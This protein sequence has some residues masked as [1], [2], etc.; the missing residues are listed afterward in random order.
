MGR[1][2]AEEAR[3]P[4][5]AIHG[6]PTETLVVLMQLHLALTPFGFQVVTI[7]IQLDVSAGK[8]SSCLFTDVYL[9]HG[10]KPQGHE[11][12][13]A[14]FAW[15]KAQHLV[16]PGF[17][18]ASHGGLLSLLHQSKAKEDRLFGVY[19]DTMQAYTM[20]PRIH[21][22]LGGKIA[23]F[24]AVRW[25]GDM[26]FP[27]LDV[28]PIN[29]KALQQRDLTAHRSPTAALCNNDAVAQDG[30]ET[31]EAA[32]GMKE[33]GGA[34][35]LHGRLLARTH[36]L[37]ARAE[38]PQRRLPGPPLPWRP[39]RRHQALQQVRLARCPPIPRRLHPPIAYS[40]PPSPISPPLAIS[41]LGMVVVAQE[42]AR[43]VGQLRSERLANLIGCCCE[44]DERLLVAEF[45]PH[46][47]LAKHLF[48]CM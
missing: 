27:L 15:D 19:H 44:G 26:L 36:R 17:A 6:V 24:Q 14:V 48:H 9:S 47:T 46:E 20:V 8:E 32:E 3:P 4:L 21:V 7:R 33:L 35:G 31:W 38:G 2:G 23:L 5:Q 30:W 1:P 40:S 42:E 12:E 34:A 13:E 28:M 37:G 22:L 41:D 43:A 18:G 10:H 25:E 16:P 29:S 11:W 39:R 45:M